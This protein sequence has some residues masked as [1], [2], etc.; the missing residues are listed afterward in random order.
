[1]KNLILAVCATTMLIGNAAA[2]IKHRTFSVPIF[3]AKSFI[4]AN[5]DGTILREQ[6]GD[7]IRPIASIS[8]L[9]VAL[10]A[11]E[12]NLTEDILIPKTRQV[13]SSIPRTV[14]TLTR[15]EL[16]TLA[17]IR[18]DNFA[19]QIL[20]INLP[21]CVDRMNEKA[22]EIG[23]I[24]TRYQEPTGLDKGNV[25]T[26]HDLLKLVMVASL[27]D[28]IT[29]ISS[30]ANAEIPIKKRSIKIHNT[31][32]LTSKFSI[33]LSKT[34]F[35]NPAGGCLVMMMNSAVGRKIFV[36]LGSKNAHTRIPDMERLVKEL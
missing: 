11:S 5:E 18:S 32:P 25:S 2:V 35:T 27:S 29:D 21:N 9:M 28:T 26:A 33:V 30:R 17:L 36:L 3:S 13:Q 16:L 23:M 8:K 10:L 34:G 22:L 20:C 14:K 1:M 19:A 12:Q 31:N 4:V 7:T 24:N 6:D 15:R